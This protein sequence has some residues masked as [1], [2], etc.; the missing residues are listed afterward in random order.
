MKTTGG[1]VPRLLPL[2]VCAAWGAGWLL[3]LQ[4]ATARV[5]FEPTDEALQAISETTAY[6]YAG[7]GMMLAAALTRFAY[8]SWLS[9]AWF[10]LLPLVTVLLLVERVKEAVL[11]WPQRVISSTNVASSSVLLTST[12][13]ARRSDTAAR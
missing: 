5:V 10:S 2:L 13:Q 3:A 12:A 9:A 7:A 4:A 1:N 6:G 11:A 8:R